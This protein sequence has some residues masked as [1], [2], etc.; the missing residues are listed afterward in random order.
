[1]T[2]LSCRTI[3]ELHTFLQVNVLKTVIYRE[4]TATSNCQNVFQN[5]LGE[6]I[7]NFDV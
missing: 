5:V 4:F 2:N 6:N 1:M 3:H 7:E